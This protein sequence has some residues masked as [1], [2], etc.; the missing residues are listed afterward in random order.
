MNERSYEIED[1]ANGTCAWLLVHETYLDWL[2]QARGL[3]WIKGK[4]GAGKST[5]LKYALQSIQ[6][7]EPL[8]SNNVTTLSFFFHGRGVEIQRTPLGLFRSLLHQLLQRFPTQLLDVVRTFKSNCENMGRPEVKWN[9]H[10][11]ELRGFL[12]TI[13][14]KVLEE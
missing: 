3:L 9:W 5:L 2:S 14:P 10:Q 6:R 12:E 8:S 1:A 7:D 13:L 11:P 4:P